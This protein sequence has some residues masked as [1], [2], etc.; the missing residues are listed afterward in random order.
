MSL[1]QQEVSVLAG[2]GPHTLHRLKKLELYTLLDLLLHLP[3]R[4]EDRTRL[5]PIN[6]LEVG[7]TS[8][9]CGRVEQVNVIPSARKIL[10]CHINDG[11]GLLA[12]KFLNFS[13]SQRKLLENATWLQCFGEVRLGYGGG[14]D[15]TLEMMHPEFALR[16]EHDAHKTENTLTPIYPCTEGL[17][18][19]L[20][21]RIIAQA[22]KM[23]DSQLV[24][25]L[26]NNFLQKFTYPTFRDALLQI[27]A[28]TGSE[29]KRAFARL[30]HEELIVHYLSMRSA[31]MHAKR[32]QSP[33]FTSKKTKVKAFLATLPFSLT[34]AQLRVIEE[35]QVDCAKPEPMLRLLQGDV[36]SGKTLV[37][38][39]TALVA[40][41]NGYQVALMVPTELLAEQ[42]CRN[43]TNWFLSFDIRILF[44]TGQLKGKAR[45]EGLKA[46]A[47]GQIDL[48]IGTHALF[49]EQVQFKKLGL[50]IVDEQHRF[51]V[52]QRL[53]LRDKGRHQTRK[54][55]ELY[56]HQLVM[57]ATPIPRTLAMM[58]YADLDVS[59]IDELPPNRTPVITRVISA[60]RREE[61]IV[62]I[63]EWVRRTYQAYWVCTLIEDSEVMQG[64]AAIATSELLTQALPNV[65]VGLVHGRMKAAEKESVMSA[66]KAQEL[67]LLVATTVIEVG[68]D[69][70]NAALM[71]IENPERLG[72]SQL[73]QLRGRVGR[74]QIESYCLLLYSSLPD[75]A[76]ERLT[77]MR[78]SN[79]GFVIAEKDLEIRGAGEVLGTRQKGQL[80]FKTVVFPR[81]EYLIESVQEI[82][83][84]L[85][86][87]IPQNIPLLINRW[88]MNAES[89]V[90]V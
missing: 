71:V 67:D 34:K 65:R 13:P 30:A 29:N 59:I 66:F 32:F 87:R 24:D 6:T 40:I 17:N 42:H 37:A 41:K 45:A 36:G 80:R 69:V 84:K 12:L 58:N 57:T 2:V 55:D 48:V 73:H 21:R 62:K 46:L 85:V 60:Q 83:D 19:S 9:V 54:G 33:V 16:T 1:L 89:Y 47:A 14:L 7:Q 4:Y 18:Q 86:D 43:F 10:V 5:C 90:D 25:Y 51:G 56:P 39:V 88:L 11:N 26:P 31:K 38:A 8:L 22:L 35:I 70:P 78:E 64:E 53:A 52:H 20:L 49:Q 79:D 23:C 50:T 27:H 77:I 15:S 28:P 68:V 3:I 82:G 74:G 44:L 81:D 76:Q 63:D 75:M 61:V 72:L